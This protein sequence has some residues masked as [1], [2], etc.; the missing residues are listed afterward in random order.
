MSVIFAVTATTS[1]V[2]ADLPLA[3]II[4]PLFKQLTILFGGIAGLYL[5][6][7]IARVFYER[8]KVRLLEDIKFNSDELNRHFKVKDSTHR[9]TWLKSVFS[10]EKK[11]KRKR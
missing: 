3:E 6:L 1:E 4:Q 9:Q 7:I 2:I 10:N 5:V 11:K 8:K